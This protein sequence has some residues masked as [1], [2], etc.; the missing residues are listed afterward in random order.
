MSNV[1]YAQN[2]KN[3]LFQENSRIFP[4]HLSNLPIFQNAFPGLK[5]VP[6]ISRTFQDF[7]CVCVFSFTA[8]KLV[9]GLPM[10][11]GTFK[12]L[13]KKEINDHKMIITGTDRFF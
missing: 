13:S 8:Q 10:Y 3:G 5:S 6:G 2:A 9:L 12:L 1:L 7:V 11:H 4:G